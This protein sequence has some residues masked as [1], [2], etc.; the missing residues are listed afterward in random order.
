MTVILAKENSQIKPKPIVNN[1]ERL[2][3]AKDKKID[4]ILPILPGKDNLDLELLF[5]ELRW[6]TQKSKTRLRW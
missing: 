1:L 3:Q 6:A 2:I 4:E 5:T